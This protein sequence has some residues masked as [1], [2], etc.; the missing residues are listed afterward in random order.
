MLSSEPIHYILHSFMGVFFFIFF[1]TTSD[2]SIGGRASLGAEIK[3]N[4]VGM[5]IV[6]E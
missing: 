6:M 5:S 3:S 1:I 4:L 2:L